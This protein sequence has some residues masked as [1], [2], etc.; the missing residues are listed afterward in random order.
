MY[1]SKA[2]QNHYLEEISFAEL[3]TIKGGNFVAV[4]GL[5]I[6]GIKLA[7]DASYGI[8]YAVGYYV[9]THG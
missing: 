3:N 8:G 7:L 6:G 5:I 1:T 9:G 2:I 4:A